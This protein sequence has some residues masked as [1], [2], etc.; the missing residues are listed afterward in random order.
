MINEDKLYEEMYGEIPNDMMDRISYILGKKANDI[1]FNKMIEK[2]AKKIKRI[3]WKTIRFTMYKVPKPSARP[4]A[5]SR[6]GF[7]RMYVPRAR[8][9]REWFGRFY[10]QHNLPYINTPCEFNLTIYEKTPSSFSLKKK[11]LA[12]LGFI[13]PWKR[14]GDFD[15]YAKSVSDSMMNGLLEDDS[16]IINSSIYLR[17]SIK[18]RIDVEIKYMENFPNI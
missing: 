7:I 14:T 15:N 10:K 16:L 5:N 6:A 3:K 1:N 13:K 17:Y 8:E 2:E 18:P 12:E 11:V 4:R 9:N